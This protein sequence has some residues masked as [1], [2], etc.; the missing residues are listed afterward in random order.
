M[1]LVLKI[2][3]FILSYTNYI[4][5][6]TIHPRVLLEYISIAVA[7]NLSLQS[8]HKGYE[9]AIQKSIQSGKLPD[10]AIGVSYGLRSPE[11]RVGSQIGKIAVSQKIPSFGT[12]KT[13]KKIAD[14]NVA[15]AQENYYQQRS[16]TIYEVKIAWYDLFYLTKAI[17]YLKLKE[18]LLSNLE[19]YLLSKF[20]NNKSIIIDILEIQEDIY[21]IHESIV[22]ME[23]EKKISEIIFNKHLLRQDIDPI[24][25]VDS[26]PIPETITPSID[27]LLASNNELKS[28]DLAYEISSYQVAISRLQSYPQFN[29]GIEY[30]IIDK[31]NDVVIPENG[32][33]IILPFAQISVPIYKTKN[34]AMI[35]QSTLYQERIHSNRMDLENEILINYYRGVNDYEESIRK[36]KL[37]QKLK[38]ITSQ[39]I[40]VLQTSYSMDEAYEK[41]IKLRLKMLDYK[42]EC[43]QSIV[44]AYKSI[45]Y[46]E[47]L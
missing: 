13:N 46:L 33:D 16:N 43:T 39:S 14:I 20:E 2:A 7:N 1:K 3:L 37:Y 8:K 35:K 34:K 23:Q 28:I 4:V 30:A 41:N 6:K 19:G 26:L 12:L 5:A 15:I 11:T 31:R 18:K 21:K 45:S 24:Y 47:L 36:S 10:P 17:D 25:I 38:T 9:I 32:K 22:S 42:L 44:N 29:I 40:S 27:S